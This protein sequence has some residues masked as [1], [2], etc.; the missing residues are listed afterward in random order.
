MTYVRGWGVGGCGIVI[1]GRIKQAVM[2]A[3]VYLCVEKS[4][5]VCESVCV[6]V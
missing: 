1:H 2:D 6:C 4:E 5:C 3:C